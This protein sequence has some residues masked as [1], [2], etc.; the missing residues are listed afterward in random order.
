MGKLKNW[1]K[2]SPLWQIIS[3]WSLAQNWPNL[4]QSCL[5]K[6][7]IWPWASPLSPAYLSILS[8][9]TPSNSHCW[10]EGNWPVSFGFPSFH[11]GFILD[12]FHL[13][14]NAPIVTD[15][16]KICASAS[17]S[18]LLAAWGPYR[19]SRLRHSLACWPL[20]LSRLPTSFSEMG[21]ELK[22]KFAVSLL[23]LSP[24]AGRQ[25]RCFD[26][27]LKSYQN[28]FRWLILSLSLLLS[29]GAQPHLLLTTRS[30][31]F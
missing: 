15:A 31:G 13:F 26:D 18:T 10:Q 4:A 9:T 21:P 5:K 3:L 19:I 7:W 8:A 20:F 16:L 2:S 11:S 25:K 28:I 6:P 1:V 29:G 17:L 24:N 30:R 14:G 12:V 23:M 22:R 27:R